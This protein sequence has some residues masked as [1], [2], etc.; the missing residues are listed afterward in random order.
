MLSSM[1]PLT[2][3]LAVSE[4]LDRK[5]MTTA[6]FAAKAQLTYNQALAIRRNAY[7]RMDLVTIAHICEALEVMPADLF[8]VEDKETQ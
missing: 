4:I 8:V 3:R 2:V 7:S 1:S 5:N 6:D